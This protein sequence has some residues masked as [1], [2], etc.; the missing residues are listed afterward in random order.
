MSNRNLI[1][2][3][4]QSIDGFLSTENDDISW[5][6]I[7]EYEGEDYGYTAM[8]ESCD[9]YIIGSKTYE[10]VKSLT[11]G[12]M[13]HLKQYKD[14]YVITRQEKEN[15]GHVQ[16]YNGNL[17]ELINS[18]KAKPGKNIYCDGGGEIVRMLMEKNLIDEYIISI[19][20]TLLGSGKRLFKGDVEGI[21]VKESGS[22]VFPSGVIQLRYSK[23]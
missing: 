4:S 15:E 9:T 2:Y 3:I 11:G 23:T 13:D 18:I 19:I 6:S 12:N 14:C 16:F 21:K 8:T 7:A 1:L 22:K 5:L 20:P 10:V 17:E